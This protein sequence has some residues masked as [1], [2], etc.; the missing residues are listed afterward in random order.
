MITIKQSLSLLRIQ[1]WSKSLFVL[2]G[3]LYSGSFNLLHQSLLAAFAFCLVSSAVYIY[4]DI[5]DLESDKLHSHKSKRMIA[6]GTISINWSCIILL[7]LLIFGF[8]V[9]FLVSSDLA[10]I[11]ASYLLINLLYNQFLKNIPILDVLSIVS[12][13]ILRVLAGTIGIG[14][15]ISWWLI[16]LT[17]LISLSIA[18][19]KR[20]L[21]KQLQVQVATRSVLKKYSIVV[22]DKLI[23][24]SGIFCFIVYLL[25]I[26]YVHGNSIYFLIT[27]IFATIGLWRFA[28]LTKYK[29][30]TDDPVIIFFD[31][32]ICKISALSFFLLSLLGVLHD[33]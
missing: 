20:R 13:F 14:L 31:D 27:I 33:L 26:K 16:L 15:A 17:A 12:G 22:L 25:Y 9:A 3:V 8:S 7:F 11:L 6:S 19:S 5:Q 18:L 2:L 29:S 32:K 1:H 4:N 10:T 24:L 23:L 28:W 30:D 21:E